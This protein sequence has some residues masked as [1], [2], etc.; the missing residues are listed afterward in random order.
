MP[1]ALRSTIGAAA[2]LLAAVVVRAAGTDPTLALTG[3][4][5]VAGGGPVLVRLQGSLQFDDL[6]QFD[7]P[8]GVIVYQGTRFAR[9]PVSGPVV[10][11][12][13]PLLAGGLAP[14]E[15]FGLLGMSAPAAAPARLVT[16]TPTTVSFVLPPEFDPG[17]ATAVLY[18]VLEGD[19]FLSNPI[20]VTLP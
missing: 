18:A 6:L 14:S 3:A 5:A 9:V 16:L 1:S 8:A 2:L 4:E 10:S 19:A 15:L 17:T 13:A 20:T 7:F 11:G 12:T